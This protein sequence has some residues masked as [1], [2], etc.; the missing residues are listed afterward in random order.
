MLLDWLKSRFES[1]LDRLEEHRGVEKTS[2]HL[3]VPINP[4]RRDIALRYF[5]CRGAAVLDG[6]AGLV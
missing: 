2:A 4:V 3:G 1:C 6:T 5:G